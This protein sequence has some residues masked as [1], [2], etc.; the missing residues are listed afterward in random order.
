VRFRKEYAPKS[1]TIVIEHAGQELVWD[2]KILE[3]SN[4]KPQRGK[5]EEDDGIERLPFDP[6]FH[7]NQYLNQLPLQKQNDLFE[8]YRNIREILEPYAH[9]SIKDLRKRIPP[10]LQKIFLICPPDDVAKWVHLTPTIVFPNGI[11]VYDTY[12]ESAEH[13]EGFGLRNR[14][15]DAT[16]IKGDY[17]G[18]V[19]LVMLARLLVPVWG[20]FLEN[21][22]EE[23]NN[24]FKEIYALRL[25]S[26]TALTMTDGYARLEAYIGRY[27][28]PEKFKNSAMEG[29]VP[30]EDAPFQTL[31]I[32]IVRR[33]AW[34][35][36]SGSD[37]SFSLIGRVYSFIEQHLEGADRQFNER[38]KPKIPESGAGGSDQ[39]NR[40]SVS[41]LIKI[42]EPYS[43]GDLTLPEAC[44][45]SPEMFLPRMHPEMDE[46]WLQLGLKAVEPLKRH[47]PQQV[48]FTILQNVLGAECRQ[49]DG[50]WEVD[51]KF[52]ERWDAL[53]PPRAIDEM[54]L[55]EDLN[56]MAVGT[57]LLC[58]NGFYDIAAIMTGTPAKDREGNPLGSSPP[59][60]EL[61]DANLAALAAQF[62][63]TQRKEGKRRTDNPTSPK[64]P[65][66]AVR[67][68]NN[69]TQDVAKYQ[70]L[71]NLPPQWL[72]QL[73]GHDGSRRYVV[74]PD[75]RNRFAE[76]AT[77]I[78]TRAL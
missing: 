15:A 39:E 27:L 26:N 9:D 37:P 69:I 22:N 38:V 50:Q 47:R 73:P 57:A 46:T 14:P 44:A 6:F 3:R 52:R 67:L 76:L 2:V 49:L 18:L 7:V 29:S 42:R 61:T 30:R 16:Y 72:K 40:A 71:L 35:D 70:W 59:P 13:G 75:F 36:F 68:I 28:T 11:R 58:Y 12:E 17:W 55:V 54:N 65:N 45:R 8:A 78:A 48:Q 19:V 24:Q 63:Y 66:V 33:L 60:A 51:P 53:F 5:A 4:K 20:Q 64:L 62:P 77:R 21:I 34:V 74:K 25:A 43:A 31:A 23:V 41:E 56:M 10:Y 1:S 32:L